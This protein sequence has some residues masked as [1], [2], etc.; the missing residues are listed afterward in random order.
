MDRTDLAS[1]RNRILN[2]VV[3]LVLNGEPSAEQFEVILRI[4]QSGNATGDIYKKAYASAQKIEDRNG[5]LDALLA[6]MDE[7]DFDLQ[8]SESQ[9]GTK[10]KEDTSTPTQD[11]VHPEG[12]GHL[13][14]Q[15]NE[16]Q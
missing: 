15:N 14:V 1:L 2:D 13:P 3:P 5:R 7:I 4:I 8:A 9:E 12:E 16:Q 10:A 11:D 6:L